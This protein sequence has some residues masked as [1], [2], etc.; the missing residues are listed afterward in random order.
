VSVTDALNM[1]DHALDSLNGTDV[2]ALPADTQARVP[3]RWR[4]GA[5]Q[6]AHRVCNA[7]HHGRTRAPRLRSPEL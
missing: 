2:A 1:L 3:S 7:G 6:E 4:I 5:R